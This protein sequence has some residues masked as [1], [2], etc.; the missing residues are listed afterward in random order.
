MRGKISFI[1]SNPRH[2]AEILLPV[3]RELQA[4]GQAC[5]VIS[6]AEL[7]GLTTPA[8]DANGARIDRLLP[9]RRHAKGRPTTV[10]SDQVPR[11]DLRRLAQRAVWTAAVGPRLRWL[12]RGSSAVVIPND[13]VFPYLQLVHSLRSRDVPFVLVQ[14][15]IRFKLPCDDEAA[16]G[17]NGA[18]AVCA[19]GQ[20]SAEYFRSIGVPADRVQV[21][22]NPRFDSVDPAYWKQE[23]EKSLAALGLGVAPLLFLSNPIELQGYGTVEF[24]LGLF[25]T[26]LREARPT[27]ELLGVPLVVKLHPHENPDDFRAEAAKIGMTISVSVNESLFALLAIARAAV[28]MASTVGLEALVFGLPLAV[29]QIPNHGFAFEYVD[30]GAALGLVPGS[31]HHGLSE[32]LA[33]SRQTQGTADA[34]V[35]RHLSNRGSAKQRV[36]EAILSVVGSC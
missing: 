33:G 36:S 30:R 26:F 32:L 13:A 31:I 5:H 9:V 15:G 7:R 28:V 1:L 4:D 23:G 27:L 8:W 22:G 17:R 16:Y 29:L 6:L 14:E 2:H 11:F 35:E 34:F 24:K 3:V 12:L 20:G 18:H 25:A 19:W 10:R 21:T